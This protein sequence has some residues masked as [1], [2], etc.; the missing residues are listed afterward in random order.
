MAEIKKTVKVMII[1][2]HPSAHKLLLPFFV[3]TTLGELQDNG[4]L[5]SY[6]GLHSTSQLRVS[7]I[8]LTEST[9]EF[10]ILTTNSVLE[11]NFSYVLMMEDGVALS[12]RIFLTV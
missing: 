3:G 9:K 6:L 4:L 11:E 2:K 7:V 5:K 10:V 1:A 8:R 12:F